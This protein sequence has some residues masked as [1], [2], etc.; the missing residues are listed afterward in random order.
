MSPRQS[1]TVLL[2]GFGPFPGVSVNASAILA[3]R[4]SERLRARHPAF[5]VVTA[6]LPVEWETVGAHI[7]A[8]LTQHRPSLALHF[9]VSHNAQGF[10]FETRAAN[11]CR[12]AADAQGSWPAAGSVDAAGPQYRTVGLPAETIVSRLTGLGLPAELSDDAG[13]YLCNA[14]LYKSLGCEQARHGRLKAGFVH[15]PTEL[16]G[17][18]YDGQQSAPTCP[19][20]WEQAVD[21]GLEIVAACLE[22]SRS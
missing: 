18:G 16:A 11:A 9:G 21:G 2:T 1:S 15:I 8:L 6:V 10:V 22:G 4:L 20:S 19:L 3:G 12:L 13:G 7:A 17:Y 14:L 5:E